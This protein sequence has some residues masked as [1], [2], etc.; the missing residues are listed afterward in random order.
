MVQQDW[1]WKEDF[2]YYIRIIAR[3]FQGGGHTVPKRG[4]SPDFR[5]VLPPVVSCLLKTWLTKG[6]S[7][8]PQDPP[9]YAPVYYSGT[10]LNWSP[11][12][13]TDSPKF[14]LDQNKVAIV[15]RWGK[16]GFALYLHT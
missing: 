8:A 2:S 4:Y 15:T 12:A 9:G 3:I 7:R 14:C 16:G 5:V 6:G 13:R 11:M 1:L 10:S